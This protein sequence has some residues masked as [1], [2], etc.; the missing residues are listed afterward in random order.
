MTPL[1]QTE[2]IA[3]RIE[4]G[5]GRRPTDRI[6]QS[7]ETAHGDLGQRRS[8]LNREGRT[9]ISERSRRQIQAAAK[10]SGVSQ[11][12]LIDLI[13]AQD[14][15][16][17]GVNIVL[18]PFELLAGPGQIA[19]AGLYRVGPRRFKIAEGQPMLS[20]ELMIQLHQEIV[21]IKRAGHVPLPLVPRDV[22]HRNVGVDDF[23]CYR[24]ETVGADYVSYAVADE[25]S[26]GRRIDRFR[27]R[28][29][30]ITGPFKSGRNHGAV[31]KRTGRLPQ[32]RIREKEKRLV[33]LNWTTDGAAELI[34]MKRR[35][36]QCRAPIIGVEY[37]VSQIFKGRAVKLICAGLG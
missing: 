26:A 27:P 21:G 1:D 15:D 31:E 7:K 2:D 14:P 6:C 22:G 33:A 24:I 23:H 20:I 18:T 30:E 4:V 35:P 37:R 8:S 13:G 28:G 10:I 9:Q 12:N 34:T 3:R 36:C 16:I 11:P 5:T 17:A 29:G 19:A 25:S 32:T